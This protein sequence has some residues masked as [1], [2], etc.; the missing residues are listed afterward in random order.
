MEVISHPKKNPYAAAND[1]NETASGWRG[2]AIG[3]AVGNLPGM[4]A[5]YLL[6]KQHYRSNHVDPKVTG[7]APFKTLSTGIPVKKLPPNMETP[8]RTPRKRSRSR[9]R[10]STRSPK[11]VPADR[12]VSM[13]RS[14][15]K[16]RSKSKSRSRSRSRS[17]SSGGGVSGR[18]GKAKGAKKGLAV[19][20]KSFYQN[21]YQTTVETFGEVKDPDA[22]WLYHGTFN[23]QAYARA[24][25]GALL[26]R[27]FQKAGCPI[28]NGNGEL[29]LRTLADSD[30]FD[31]SYTYVL[32]TDETY[33]TNTVA[34]ANNTTFFD[35]VE[36]CSALTGIAES[37]LLYLT[38]G[39]NP[40]PHRLSLY[41]QD[42]DG[43][44]TFS[45]L[46]STIDL[47]N[48]HIDL[49]ISSILTMQNR[50]SGAGTANV[51]LDRIDNQPLK[52]T[53]FD[54]N[55]ADPRLASMN[56]ATTGLNQPVTNLIG[57]AYQEGVKTIRNQ[58]ITLLS[59]TLDF[60]NAPPKK[61]WT[62][63]FSRDVG[64]FEPGAIAKSVVTETYSGKLHTIMKKMRASQVSAQG[65]APLVHGKSRLIHHEE[66]LRTASTNKVEVAYSH[67][68][69]CSAVVVPKKQV[70]SLTSQVFVNSV[71]NN[72]G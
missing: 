3:L 22:I 12:D 34:I 57:I 54:F 53:T 56:L 66:M 6:G 25:V 59:G 71:V 55:H 60:Q 47:H 17:R 24:I 42:K 8:S 68:Y 5:G 69:K 37:I 15:S 61:F 63:C 38:N 10:P 23:P 26:R 31:L 58:Q 46:A 48:L 39:F 18:K 9:G 7:S 32:P 43:A 40:I 52:T 50:T 29:P 20:S 45:R 70:S 21:G 27:L 30:G 19:S 14:R 4:F 1:A 35:L 51:E 64:T 41:A 13:K 67:E 28:Q 49:Q 16:S 33:A 44:S 72:N 2:A 36:S 62:N 65:L 11:M